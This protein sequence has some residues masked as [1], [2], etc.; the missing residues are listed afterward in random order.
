[1]DRFHSCAGFR[2]TVFIPASCLFSI[3][4]KYFL[5][6]YCVPYLLRGAGFLAGGRERIPLS[7]LVVSSEWPP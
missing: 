4:V 1:M 3:F 2:T 7:V 6:L 5:M